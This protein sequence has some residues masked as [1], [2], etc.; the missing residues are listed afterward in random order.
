[1]TFPVIFH[2]FGFDLPA[3]LVFEALAY[4]LGFQLF[5]FLRRRSPD[6]GLP[7]EQTSWLLV[8]AVF[9]ALAGSKLLAWAEHPQHYW[10]LRYDPAA[11][12]AGKTIV[13]GFLGGWAGVEI[14]KKILRVHSRTGDQFVFPL[15]LGIA[16]GRIGCFLTGLPDQTYGTATSLPWGVDFGDGIHRHPTQL[17]ESLFAIVFA[18]VLIALRRHAG[19]PGSLFRIFLAGY[20]LFRFAVEWIK[21][22]PKGYG[23]ISAIQIASL[24]GALLCV[25]QLAFSTRRELASPSPSSASG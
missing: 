11:W 15:L 17:Y 12:M 6:A 18:V 14:A 10:A 7:F 4:T 23:G 25:G 20:L 2:P 19:A 16:V 21:P 22:S 24:V 1:M 8:G 5:L 9:G 13:G 3:H